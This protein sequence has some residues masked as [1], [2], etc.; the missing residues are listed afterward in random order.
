MV[1]S[2]CQ[3]RPLTKA[4]EY[5]TILFLITLTFVLMALTLGNHT[6]GKAK[7][8]KHDIKLVA[9]E[10]H[11]LLRALGR[12]QQR[13]PPLLRTPSFKSMKTT[14]NIARDRW[15]LLLPGCYW[16]GKKQT[17]TP[18]DSNGTASLFFLLECEVPR[19]K[20]FLR[21]LLKLSIVITKCSK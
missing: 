7:A 14:K 20:L 5:H 18:Q 16:R 19:K 10:N 3:S 15:R 11:T 4:S 13:Y 2:G 9:V 17:A 21:Q 12:W 1:H 8:M 6:Y